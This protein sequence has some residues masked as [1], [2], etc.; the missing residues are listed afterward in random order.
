MAKKRRYW[1]DGELVTIDDAFEIALVG[2]RCVQQDNPGST[3]MSHYVSGSRLEAPRQTGFRVVDAN[4]RTIKTV[5]WF[6]DLGAYGAEP[7]R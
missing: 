3:I 4:D 7:D 6:E 2:A 1:I 5:T